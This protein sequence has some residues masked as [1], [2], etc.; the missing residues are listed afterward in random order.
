M[1]SMMNYMGK[2]MIYTYQRLKDLNW[3]TQNFV[4]NVLNLEVK[5]VSRKEFIDKL[6]N[7]SDASYKS[8]LRDL[9]IM[10]ERSLEYQKEHR[11]VNDKYRIIVPQERKKS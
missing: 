1:S 7:Q 3:P 9:R 2:D 5:E 8:V 6:I 11:G 10:T 4:D